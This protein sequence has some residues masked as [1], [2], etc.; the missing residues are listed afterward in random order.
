MT[1][2]TNNTVRKR[3]R[4]EE[5]KKELSSSQSVSRKEFNKPV[6]IVIGTLG[7]GKSTVL[8]R[9]IDKDE[10]QTSDEVDGCTQEFQM[11]KG[12]KYDICDSMGLGDPNLDITKW[13]DKYNAN[14][15]VKGREI[16][17]VLLVVKGQIRPTN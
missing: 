6:V 3:D 9:L 11:F 7:I 2:S 12:E 4:K 8:N 17:L 13:M 1:E 5:E 15:N 14:P 10:F 16:A